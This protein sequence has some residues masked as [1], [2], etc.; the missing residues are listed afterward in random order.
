MLDEYLEEEIRT[1][2]LVI[3]NREVGVH[4]PVVESQES[5]SDVSINCELDEEQKNEVQNLLYE[6]SDVFTDIP[7]FTDIAEHDIV[8]TSQQPVRCRP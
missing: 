6:Y 3:G 2:P 7:G 5:I 1:N 4:F 8:L